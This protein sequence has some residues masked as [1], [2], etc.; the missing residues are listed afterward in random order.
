MNGLVDEQ[1]NTNDNFETETSSN[2]KSSFVRNWSMRTRCFSM[3]TDVGA[4][5]SEPDAAAYRSNSSSFCFNSLMNSFSR[6]FSFSINSSLVR[7]VV[8]TDDWHM[9]SGIPLEANSCN[10]TR[11]FYEK[12]NQESVSL[13]RISLFILHD[14][15]LSE[16]RQL[17]EDVIVHE[18]NV[19]SKQQVMHSIVRA[20]RVKLIY[21]GLLRWH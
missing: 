3:V 2:C 21:H 7:S 9:T 19:E 10:S 11:R 15:L 13:M 20:L 5:S 16:H 6:H 4:P 14:L 8:Y 12:E 17:V 18:R 1:M